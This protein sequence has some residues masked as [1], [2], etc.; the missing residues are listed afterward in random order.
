MFVTTYEDKFDVVQ[1]VNYVKKVEGV[2]QVGWEKVLVQMLGNLGNFGCSYSKGHCQQSYPALPIQS[3][4]P[5]STGG[6]SGATQQPSVAKGKTSLNL[7]CYTYG[8]VGYFNRE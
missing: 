8:V 3:A 6:Q 2:K 5:T 4:L 1:V 7:D